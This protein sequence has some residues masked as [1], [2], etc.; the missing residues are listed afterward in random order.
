MRSLVRRYPMPIGFIAALCAVSSVY[1]YGLGPSAQRSM[2]S[3]TATNLVN[4]RTNPL[5][6]LVA[7][8]FVS[9]AEPWVWIAF[10]VAGLFPVA[11]RFGN[12]RALALV[13]GGQ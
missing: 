5:G 7:S 13:C 6:T 3:V 8:A 4:L 9:E 12:L 2:V 10:A 11:H 1:A